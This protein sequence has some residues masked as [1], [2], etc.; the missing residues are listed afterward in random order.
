MDSQTQPFES[1]V[2]LKMVVTRINQDTMG[3]RFITQFLGSSCVCK[4][5]FFGM[6]DITDQDNGPIQ[7]IKDQLLNLSIIRFDKPTLIQ[8]HKSYRQQESLPCVGQEVVSTF[9]FEQPIVIPI[10]K[11]VVLLVELRDVVRSTLTSLK[12]EQ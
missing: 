6:I 3:Y 7:D 10:P 12:L 4:K 11:E 9:V 8:S 1:M 2:L 5:G